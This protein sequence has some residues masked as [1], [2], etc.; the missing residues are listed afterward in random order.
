M[1]SDAIYFI[2]FVVRHIDL[3]IKVI[4]STNNRSSTGKEFSGVFR[5]IR[6]HVVLT[7]LNYLVGNLRLIWI[8]V[9]SNFQFQLGSVKQNQL[10]IDSMQ[11]LSS[12]LPFHCPY[13]SLHLRPDSNDDCYQ[14]CPDYFSNFL[15]FRVNL[16][17]VWGYFQQFLN[18]KTLTLA[19]WFGLNEFIKWYYFK[20][21]CKITRLIDIK[22]SLGLS[23]T[24]S[25]LC[26]VSFA[27]Y[28]C[29]FHLSS[30]A[31]SKSTSTAL[32]RLNDDWLNIFIKWFP[33]IY[34]SAQKLI[35][36]SIKHK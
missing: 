29:L 24:S 7:D 17:C 33:G 20:C 12:L 35:I 28:E 2:K 32:S 27:A 26:C 31:F 4:T 5:D 22:T 11:L 34:R 19:C 1:W 13:L 36:R 23:K 14:D 16:L 30:S 25:L 9:D 10:M 8:F 18:H 3:I 6:T 21:H 15:P